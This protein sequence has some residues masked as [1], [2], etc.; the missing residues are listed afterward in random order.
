MSL[1]M[2]REALALR[3]T[4]ELSVSGRTFPV[5][6]G[7][8]RVPTV[9]RQFVPVSND[10]VPDAPCLIVKLAD[11][12]QDDAG[13]RA[14][15]SVAAVLYAPDDEQG[16]AEVETLLDG[17]ATALLQQPWLDGGRYHL[18]GPW[19]LATDPVADQLFGGVLEFAVQLPAVTALLGPSG[20]PLA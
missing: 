6:D 14:T 8:P 11:W 20:E 12:T 9:Y 10:G 7:D 3:M 13:R 18:V 15:A 4:S 19:K 17:L 1:V 2:A 16:Y 5:P